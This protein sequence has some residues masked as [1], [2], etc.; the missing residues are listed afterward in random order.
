MQKSACGAISLAML[1]DRCR[2]KLGSI[3]HEISFDF[4]LFGD[5]RASKIMVRVMHLRETVDAFKYGIADSH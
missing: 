4:K 3:I 5:D 2:D 1:G